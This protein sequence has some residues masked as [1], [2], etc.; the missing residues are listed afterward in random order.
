MFSRGK[1]ILQ[2]TLKKNAQNGGTE[3]IYIVF[4]EC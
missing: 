3:G 1:L 4:I 2:A